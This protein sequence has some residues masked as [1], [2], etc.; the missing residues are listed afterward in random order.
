MRKLNEYSTGYETS[1]NNSQSQEYGGALAP[2]DAEVV[3]GNDRLNAK[4][5]EGLHRINSLIHQM[6]KRTTLNPHYDISQLRARLNHL[7]M[8]FDFNSNM[9]LQEV[10]NFVVTQGGNAFGVTPTTDLSKGFDT[11]SDLP[12]YNLEIRMLK[13]DGG[14]KLEG[15]MLPM[16]R[17]DQTARLLS[18]P[19]LRSGPYILHYIVHYL[20]LLRF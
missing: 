15:K 18:I 7:N 20:Q 10:N 4:T 5:A 11:G 9:P 1:I 12:Q 3:Q 17:R 19:L 6:F 16:N 2:V 8:D 14:F 13:I